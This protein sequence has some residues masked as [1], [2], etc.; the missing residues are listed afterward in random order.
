[1]SS[2]AAYAHWTVVGGATSG[3]Q[4]DARIGGR[5]VAR[6]L[7]MRSRPGACQAPSPAQTAGQ[8][9]GQT[10]GF[11]MR[12]SSRRLGSSG[13]SRA[14]ASLIEDRMSAPSHWRHRSR[15]DGTTRQ[16]SRVTAFP[17]SDRPAC[18]P[19]VIG[20]D[21]QRSRGHRR[22]RDRFAR[23]VI[24]PRRR[25]GRPRS[26]FRRRGARSQRRQLDCRLSRPRRRTQGA[27]ERRRVPSVHMQPEVQLGK[28]SVGPRC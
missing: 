17:K 27:C 26:R 2:N 23:N 16:S 21:G 3:L 8:E 13:P 1:V 5:C 20:F 10:T 11:H 22:A 12:S 24:A 6:S 25:P 4:D 28:L 14:I 18:S 19:G 9:E 7:E 15:P